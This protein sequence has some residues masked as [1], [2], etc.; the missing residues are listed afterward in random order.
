MKKILA[1]V[2]CVAM[3][4]AVFAGCTNDN[5]KA[6]DKDVS[7]VSTVSEAAD[8]DKN[9]DA[10]GAGEDLLAEYIELAKPSIDVIKE[11][12]GDSFSIDIVD[13]DGAFTY[14]YK[15]NEDLGVENSEL[16]AAFDEQ[17]ATQDSVYEMLLDEMSEFG[18]ENPHVIVEYLDFKGDVITNYDYKK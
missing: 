7:G 9:S 5:K 4:V 13:R 1:M 3:S 2:L 8:D 6:D 18:I 17:M 12:M 10:D 14:V 15:L 16:K 11:A